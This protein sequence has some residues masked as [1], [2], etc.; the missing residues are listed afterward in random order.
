MTAATDMMI[1]E[2]ATATVIVAEVVVVVV[3]DLTL[4]DVIVTRDATED[5]RHSSM[6]PQGDVIKC[7]F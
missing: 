7:Y 1:E 5:I 2:V 6:R 3:V 4:V